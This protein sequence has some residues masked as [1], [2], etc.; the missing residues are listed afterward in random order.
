MGIRRGSISTPIITDGL[1]FHLD[2]NNKASYPKTDDKVY[3][4]IS[5]ISGSFIN[6]ASVD[7]STGQ[8]VFTFDGVEDAIY[9]EG[10]NNPDSWLIPSNSTDP[11][12]VSV[13]FNTKKA[14]LKQYIITS[15]QGGGSNWAIHINTS[16]IKFRLRQENTTVTTNSYAKLSSST[17]LS[18]DTWYNVVGVFTGSE[19]KLYL[20]GVEVDT[21]IPCN[22]FKKTNVMDGVIGT[23]WFQGKPNQQH[24]KGQIGPVSFYRSKFLT[25]YEILHNYNALKG[26]FGL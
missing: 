19:A 13:W 5:P 11:F 2:A 12:S 24:F 21:P 9:L 20:N 26:R 17:Y 3:N 23:Y 22:F 18:N 15:A 16:Q 6:D 8:G 14:N 1:Y 25:S 7:Y 4:T 10:T